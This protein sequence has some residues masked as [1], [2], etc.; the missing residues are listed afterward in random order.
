MSKS[1]RSCAG[2]KRAIG[3]SPRTLRMWRSIA[4]RSSSVS[5]CGGTAT[6]SLPRSGTRAPS[7]RASWIMSATSCQRPSTR[8]MRAD[9]IKVCA[10]RSGLSLGSC[11]S[12]SISASVCSTGASRSM[13]SVRSTRSLLEYAATRTPSACKRISSARALARDRARRMLQIDLAQQ[14]GGLALAAPL[15]PRLRELEQQL[16]ALRQLRIALEQRIEL[17]FTLAVAGLEHAVHAVDARF[18]G[19]AAIRA[20]VRQ[21]ERFARLLRH[22]QLAQQLAA[23]NRDAI[24]DARRLALDHA[25]LQHCIFEASGR[26]ECFGLRHRCCARSRC[27]ARSGAPSAPR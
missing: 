23:S 24:G 4:A 15:L 20:V 8:A 2:F 19:D 14:V 7:L 10:R 3:F 25:Q 13:R 9:R 22:V 11:S 17:G 6:A 21:R 5:T 18:C 12:A 26:D 1:V 16:F 27:L